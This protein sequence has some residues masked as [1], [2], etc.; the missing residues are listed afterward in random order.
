MRRGC[1][2]RV[3]VEWKCEFFHPVEIP[4]Q[5]AKDI[6]AFAA[7][8]RDLNAESFILFVNVIIQTCP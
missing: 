6:F 5:R 4:L 7:G 8:N 3:S 2:G 1:V